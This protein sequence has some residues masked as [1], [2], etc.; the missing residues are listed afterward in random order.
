[1]KI[2]DKIR[3]DGMTGV[4]VG[5]ISEGKYAP[6]YPP[7]EWAYLQVGVLVETAEAGLIHFAGT[8]RIEVD[9]SSG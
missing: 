8:D 4:V 7:H 6:G 2:G 1:M 5:L 3:A 9:Q